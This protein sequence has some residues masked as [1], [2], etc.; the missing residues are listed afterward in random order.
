MNISISLR[1]VPPPIS[2]TTTGHRREETTATATHAHRRATD[3]RISGL[4]HADFRQPQARKAVPGESD[5]YACLPE[6]HYLSS[7]QFGKSDGN[8][9]AGS[10]GVALRGQLGEGRGRQDEVGNVRTWRTK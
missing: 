10:W 2:D 8:C 5:A 3:N 6:G 4:L 1:C 9:L 7:R